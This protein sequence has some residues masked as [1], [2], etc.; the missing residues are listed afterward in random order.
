MERRISTSVS[1][2]ADQLAALDAEAA[3][4]FRSRSQL[5][6]K[7][8]TEYLYRRRFEEAEKA[9]NEA[10]VGVRHNG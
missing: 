6:E 10:S 4:S 7:I 8:I 1:L 3:R 2:H 5:F 9:R